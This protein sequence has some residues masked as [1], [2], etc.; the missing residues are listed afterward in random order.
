MRSVAKTGT[1]PLEAREMAAWH[2]LIRAHARVVRRLEA[3]LE[4]EMGLTLPA[5]EVLAHLSE[6][7]G[8]RLRMSDLAEYAVLTPSGLTR[9]IDKLTRDG[10][11]ERAR[12]DADARV[13]YAVLTED[14]R[15]RLEEA[16]P[17]HLRGVRQHLVDRL[18]PEQQ[19]A[20][21]DA[22]GP[23]AAEADGCA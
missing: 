13:V 14:G 4:A 8:R 9:L 17:V 22:L 19:A 23:L 1:R 5:Y 10:L 18:D 6:A 12:C 7:P 15:R 2:A 3:E 16:Y 21:A 20:L 11:V